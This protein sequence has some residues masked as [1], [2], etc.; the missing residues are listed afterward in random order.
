MEALRPLLNV[1][2]GI[3]PQYNCEVHHYHIGSLNFGWSK[4]EDHALI[5]VLL[6][7]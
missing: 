3:K 5:E 6:I 4:I 2:V 7:S 1:F